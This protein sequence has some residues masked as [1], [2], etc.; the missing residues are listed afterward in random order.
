MDQIR[1][2]LPFLDWAPVCFTS[3]VRREGLPELFDTIDQAAVEFRR[4]IAPGEVTQ[5]LRAAIERRPISVGGAPLTLY[6]AA[7]VST[8][9]PTFALRVNRPDGIHFSYA[10]YLAKSLRLALGLAGTPIRLSLRRGTPRARTRPGT[11][12]AAR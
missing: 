4:R 1:D 8:E 6:S 7:Q 5:T 11:R 12:K 3:A 10:R 9:P 2:R